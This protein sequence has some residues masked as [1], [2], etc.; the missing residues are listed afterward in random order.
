M[1]ICNADGIFNWETV[2]SKGIISTSNT[3]PS[4]PGGKKRLSSPLDE[5][6]FLLAHR[7][8]PKNKHGPLCQEDEKK[9]KGNRDKTPE[10]YRLGRQGKKKSSSKKR[11]LGSKSIGRQIGA[12]DLNAQET[13]E[14][15]SRN[16]H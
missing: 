14:D 3:L 15:D 13:Q 5:S 1:D 6:K 2:E 4:K 16:E 11:G 7:N 10:M 12:N 8:K 9:N